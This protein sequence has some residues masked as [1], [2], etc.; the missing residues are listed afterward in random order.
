MEDDLFDPQVSISSVNPS[1]GLNIHRPNQPHPSGLGANESKVVSFRPL[2]GIL[3]QGKLIPLK[4]APFTFEVD[5]VGTPEEAV[6]YGGA[7]LGTNEVFA[8]TKASK[9]WSLADVQIKCDVLTLDNDR[10]N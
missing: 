1:G 6:A 3:S 2:S 10:A 9:D 4:V 7:V 8:E 5:I